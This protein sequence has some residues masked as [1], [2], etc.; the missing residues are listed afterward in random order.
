MLE[1]LLLAIGLT[2]ALNLFAGLNLL[3]SKQTSKEVNKQIIPV[4]ILYHLHG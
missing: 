1:K 3:S 2:F 4:S